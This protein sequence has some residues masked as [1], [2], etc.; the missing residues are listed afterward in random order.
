MLFTTHTFYSANVIC[1]GMFVLWL[2]LSGC[3]FFKPPIIL[4]IGNQKWTKQQFTALI[5]KKIKD[6]SLQDHLNKKIVKN[7]KQ[8]V[9]TDLLIKQVITQWATEQRVVISKEELRAQVEK[10]RKGYSHLSAFEMYLNRKQIQPS[11]LEEGIKFNLL[12]KK[13]VKHISAD[14]EPPGEKEIKLFYQK[15]LNDF[16]KKARIQIRHIFHSQKATLSR[17]LQ[18]LEDGQSFKTLARKFSKA[19]EGDKL[20]WVEEGM[21]QIFD[22][23]FTLKKKQ[24]SPIWRSSHGWHIVQVLDKQAGRA[25]SFEEAKPTITF[26]LMHNR[27]K[28]R[29]AKW[30]DT[31]GKKILVFKNQEMIDKINIL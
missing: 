28:A 2:T 29:F 13:V 25:L 10:A 11:D 9:I 26:M 5:N 19:P 15:H 7:I 22:Q 16:K 23:A 17:A 1:W 12:V 8:Q 21:F 20:Q 31:E 18:L 4:Q 24:V 3:S 6:S 27:Q 14:I 30:L